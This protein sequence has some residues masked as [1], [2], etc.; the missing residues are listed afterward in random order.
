MTIYAITLYRGRP[1]PEFI[2]T[3]LPDDQNNMTTA[4][5]MGSTEFT[6][7]AL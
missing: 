5:I 2:A 7:P 6:K 3:C 1:A 4:L